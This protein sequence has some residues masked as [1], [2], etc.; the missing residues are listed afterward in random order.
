MPLR[1]S[2]PGRGGALFIPSLCHPW[3]GGIASST[4]PATPTASFFS[5]RFPAN[6]HIRLPVSRLPIPTTRAAS[7]F[8]GSIR[9]QPATLTGG[10]GRF[11]RWPRPLRSSPQHGRL[12][13]F[14]AD[15]PCLVF[16]VFGTSA[17]LSVDDGPCHL[18]FPRPIAAASPLRSGIVT[19][20][21]LALSRR[22]RPFVAATAPINPSPFRGG[23]APTTPA[24][25]S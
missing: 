16:L 12:T 4:W 9:S 18:N 19:N 6:F 20:K 8:V 7:V 11:V 17:P 24:D 14:V 13:N 21:F 2:Q 3:H 23:N 10:P 22:Q 15:A 5:T 25:G 1:S